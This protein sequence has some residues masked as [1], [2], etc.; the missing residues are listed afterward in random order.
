MSGS[1]PDELARLRAENTALRQRLDEA[2]ATCAQLSRVE[3]EAAAQQA[4]LQAVYDHSPFLLAV[5]DARRRVLFANRAFQAY[6]GFPVDASQAAAACGVLGCVRALDDPKGCGFGPRCDTCALRL[7][8]VDTLSTGTSHHD[9]EHATEVVRGAERRP[10]VW[11][12]S[13]AR[14]PAEGPARALLVLQDVTARKRDQ[15]AVVASEA[16]LRA[17]SAHLE[18]LR[19]EERARLSREIHDQLGQMVTRLIL[20]LRRV[21]HGLEAMDDPRANALL[22]Q[23]VSTSELAGGLLGS[24]RT[25]AHDLRPSLL[26]L[27]GLPAAL[28][29][30]AQE[31]ERQTAIPCRLEVPPD[32]A[33]PAADAAIVA[34]RVCQEALTNVKRHAS[35]TQ[36]RMSFARDGDRWRLEV[37]DDGDGLPAEAL[38]DPSALGLLGMRERARSLGGTVTFSRAPSGRGT[39]VVLALPVTD[40]AT[41]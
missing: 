8:L 5:I 29:H 35:A 19:E 15:D 22:D 13:I 28:E 14:L 10:V 41:P 39:L 21:E 38:E 23:V 2:E 3:R 24:V 7:A 1:L 16:R 34:F 17:L 18:T 30:E 37:E 11:Q 31:F 32:L 20:D 25:I 36:V 27:L 12:G 26:D 40:G 4:E 9:V 6:A 33:P